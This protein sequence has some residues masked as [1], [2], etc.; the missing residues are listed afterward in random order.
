MNDSPSAW[1]YVKL[2]FLVV[3]W[4]LTAILGSIISVSPVALV[5]YRTFFSALVL[6]AILFFRKRLIGIGPKAT[7]VLFGTGAL[8]ALHWI[9]FFASARMSTISVSLAGMSTASLWTS[10]L[11]PLVY[12]KKI[13]ARDVFFG[14]L[15]MVGLYIIF[16]FEFNHFGG[17]VVSLV[18]AVVASLFVV[19]NSRLVK[20]YDAVLITGYEMAG[21]SLFSLVALALYLLSPWGSGTPTLPTSSDWVPLLILTLICTVYGYSLAASLMRQFS[22]FMMNLTVNLEPIY[23]IALAVWIFGEKE[24][25]T[26]G[27]YLGTLVILLSVLLYPVWIR[28]EN[29]REAV[30][31]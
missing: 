10:I 15:A 4:S 22:A 20:K 26:H 13:K 5:F 24:K 16:K 6:V 30:K 7:L 2:H 21:A 18:S 3:I 11:E 23:G 8:L 31:L 12:G 28:F 27:F 1:S 29:R 14:L 17:L 25:M 9:L 19:A